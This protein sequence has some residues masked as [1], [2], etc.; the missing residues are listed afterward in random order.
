MQHSP[1]QPVLYEE[2]IHALEPR[3]PGLYVDGTVGAGGHAR[4]IL[5]ACAPDGRLL[6]L[7]V[8]PQALAVARGSLAGYGERL[9]LRQASYASVIDVLRDSGWEAVDGMVLD[10]GVSS[11]QLDTD[12]RGFSFQRDAPLD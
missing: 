10:L 3:S 11:M 7:D 9:I 12:E 4:G 5:D 1:H 6:G 8:D 2:I